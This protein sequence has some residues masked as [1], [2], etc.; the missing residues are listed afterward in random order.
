MRPA[1]FAKK[2]DESDDAITA[3]IGAEREEELM[4]LLH[5]LTDFIQEELR[6]C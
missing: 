1:G 4:E 5:R 3:F 2:L 6:Q